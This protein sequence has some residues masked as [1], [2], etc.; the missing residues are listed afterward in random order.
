MFLRKNRRRAGGETYAYWTLCESVRQITCPPWSHGPQQRKA[1]PTTRDMQWYR[2]A[3]PLPA[4]MRGVRMPATRDPRDPRDAGGKAR[5]SSFLT[6]TDY[7]SPWSPHGPSRSP[8]SPHGLP[9]RAAR[10]VS[11][12]KYFLL[13]PCRRRYLSP[14]C[15]KDGVRSGRERQRSSGLRGGARRSLTTC[16]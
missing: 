8:W 2:P 6:T 16:V 11:I 12:V 7:L 5:R 10:R 15:E 3:W 13:P 1:P 4:L 14:R 9:C